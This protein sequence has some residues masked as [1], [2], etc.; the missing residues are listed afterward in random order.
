MKEKIVTSFAPSAIGPYS[1]AIK[2]NNTVYTS[3]VIPFDAEG[4]FSPDISIQTKQALTNLKA[5]L[6]A[7]GADLCDVV[8][9]TCILK[10]WIHLPKSIRSMA[11]IL[12]SR[13]LRVAAWKQQDYQKM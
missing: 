5:V 6:A 1:Q 10:I 2:Y 7:A 8:K 13:I 12:A 4:K 9:V 3:G 11:N